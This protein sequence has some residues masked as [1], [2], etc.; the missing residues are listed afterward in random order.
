MKASTNSCTPG[1][2]CRLELDGISHAKQESHNEHRQQ[3][4]SRLRRPGLHRLPLLCG[5]LDGLF[6]AG[7]TA[8]REVII[9]GEGP[10]ADR[11]MPNA[12]HAAH[13]QERQSRPPKAERWTESAGHGIP[14]N[15]GSTMDGESLASRRPR[16]R[17]P[18]A[19][20]EGG[21][22]SRDLR[23]AARRVGRQGPSARPR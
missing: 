5:T 16:S 21:S 15:P 19:G 22:R 14:T 4:H 10:G 18:S 17:N 20:A 11:P 12:R 6:H 7:A 1:L 2:A 3:A 23:S 13:P 9:H 8:E